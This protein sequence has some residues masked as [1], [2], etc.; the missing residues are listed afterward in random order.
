MKNNQK[1]FDF[2]I[3]SAFF[4]FLLQAFSLPANAAN[5][6]HSPGVSAEQALK[7]LKEGNERFIDGKMV[8]NDSSELRRE[9][10]VEGQKPHTIILS[11]SD[12]RVPPEIVFDQGLGDLFVVRVAGNILDDA[13]SASIEYAVEHL[14]T[15]LIVVMGHDS[16]GAVKAALSASCT[17]HADSPDLDHLISTIQRSVGCKSEV[18]MNLMKLL[19]TDP[20]LRKPVMKNAQFVAQHLVKRSRIVKKYVDS[21]KLQII[22]AIYSLKAGTVSFGD[23]TQFGEF[24][25]E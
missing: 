14:G 8:H 11:C 23:L 1:N 19:E 4:F 12:S 5:S 16:C 10:V 13:T 2:F 6:R 7:L 20:F 18:Q 3:C 22:P 17:A 15:R 24:K 25:V 21:G 9:S